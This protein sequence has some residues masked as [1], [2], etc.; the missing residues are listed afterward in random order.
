[1]KKMSTFNQNT[2][3]VNDV[4]NVDDYEDND[5]KDPIL[6]KTKVINIILYNRFFIII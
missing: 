2:M 6:A 4:Y 3:F 1:M 5:D